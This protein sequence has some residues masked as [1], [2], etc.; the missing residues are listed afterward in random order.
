MKILWLIIVIFFFIS[1]ANFTEKGVT[2]HLPINDYVQSNA[3]GIQYKIVSANR[4]IFEYASGLSM[5]KE[6]QKMT[7]TTTMAAFSMTKTITAIAVL[8]LAEQGKLSLKDYASKYVEHPYD[9]SITVEQLLTHTSGITSPIPLS[10]I[11]LASEDLE[12]NKKEALKVVLKEHPKQKFRAGTAYLYSNISYWLLGELIEK[13]SGMS[14]ETY[15]ENMIFKPLKL[16]NKE[17]SF[18]II[19]PDNNAKGYLKRFSFMNLLKGFLLDSKYYSDYEDGWLTIEDVYLNGTSFGGLI[20][21]TDAFAVI[22]Q[23]LLKY[24]SVLLTNKSILYK[25][26]ILNKGKSI[27]MTLAWHVG[28]NSLGIYYFK[29]GGGAG[30]HCEMRVYPDRGIAS[31]VMV[32]RTV[33]DT[34]DF[35]DT[36]D[37]LY[38]YTKLDEV[39]L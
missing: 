6:Q 15:V 21:S 38:F 30:F 35:L 7:N 13:V 20:G 29:E 9:E 22:L 10:W 25:K 3:P 17:I 19:H 39:K 37:D 18:T 34:K 26:Y 16:T 8:Q 1:C 28:K 4:I 5:I 32:N 36:Q 24:D 14:Y 2:M 11:H 27:D 31:I 12:F 23:D 33:F